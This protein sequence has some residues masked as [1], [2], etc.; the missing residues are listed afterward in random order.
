M[1]RLRSF[2]GVSGLVLRHFRGFRG[3][4]EFPGVFQCLLIIS[5][6]VYG[7]KCEA[8]KCELMGYASKTRY[9]LI[10][11]TNHDMTHLDRK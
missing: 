3:I 10:D 11:R 8:A 9:M 7:L 6:G 1:E 5:G 4:R 2:Q